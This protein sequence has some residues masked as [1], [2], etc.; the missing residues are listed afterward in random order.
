MCAT[1]RKEETLGKPRTVPDPVL[2]SCTAA[3]VGQNLY[4]AFQLCRAPKVP[5]W[6][7]LARRHPN[8]HRRVQPF[9]ER[10]KLAGQNPDLNRG[11][12]DRLL[13]NGWLRASTPKLRR[14]NV[15][16]TQDHLEFASGATVD[17]ARYALGSLYR[18]GYTVS[19][20]VGMQSP[21]N[22]DTQGVCNTRARIRFG[23]A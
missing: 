22:L 17:P 5:Q 21:R 20:S 10:P 1:R 23:E 11:R 18:T 16:A 8:W 6:R 19:S 14:G 2:R 7:A 3:R 12:D 9:K 13:R 4:N 15:L